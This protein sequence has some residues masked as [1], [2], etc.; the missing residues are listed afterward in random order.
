MEAW[1]RLM[2][3]A[4]QSYLDKSYHRAMTLNQS[5]LL[6]AH[7]AFDWMFYSDPEK[8]IA[9]VMVSNFSLIDSLV[10]QADYLSAN[11]QFEN[12]LGFLKS[13]GKYPDLSDEQQLAIWHG[14]N[15]LRKEWTQFSKDYGDAFTQ[16][17]KQLMQQFNRAL[18]QFH[19]YP[20][21]V[22]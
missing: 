22:H 18:T 14:A 7:A 16:Q 8:A 2:R 15:Q 21:G 19:K 6:L 1:E 10:A 17:G 9:A 5:A 12:S 3:Q 11:S 20:F 4:R 13:A